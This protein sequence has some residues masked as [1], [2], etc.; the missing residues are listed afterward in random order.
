MGRKWSHNWPLWFWPFVIFNHLI[1]SLR[2]R[3]I[4]N[5]F[6]VWVNWWSI[7]KKKLSSPTVPLMLHV[8]FEGPFDHRAANSIPFGWHLTPISLDQRSPPHVLLH[9]KR[10]WETAKFSVMPTTVT[11]VSYCSVESNFRTTRDSFCVG[12]NVNF[13]SPEVIEFIKL[14]QKYF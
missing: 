3:N 8:V 2:N 13:N 11:V 7:R 6:H 10:H 4:S 9:M 12:V 14:N 5:T 1:V